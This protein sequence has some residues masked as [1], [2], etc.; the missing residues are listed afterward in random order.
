M[1]FILTYKSPPDCPLR[2]RKFHLTQFI[3]CYFL[4]TIIVYTVTDSVWYSMPW[5]LFWLIQALQKNSHL[6]GRLDI[7]FIVGDRDTFAVGLRR[8]VC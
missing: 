3:V 4:S 7:P 5:L 1:A 6:L 8:K 2:L